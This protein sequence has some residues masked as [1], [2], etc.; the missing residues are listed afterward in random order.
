LHWFAWAYETW[1]EAIDYLKSLPIWRALRQWA[2]TL[3]VQVRR[4]L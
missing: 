4:W 2:H 1:R 3:G